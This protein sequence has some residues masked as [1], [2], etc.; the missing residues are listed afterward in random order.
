MFRGLTVGFWA[1]IFVAAALGVCFC[2]TALAR[3]TAQAEDPVSHVTQLNRDALAAIDKR[4]FEKARELLKRAL[5]VCDSAGLDKHA[6]AAR[7]HVHM[8]VVIIEGFKNRELGLKQFAKALEIEPGIA[9]TKSLSTPEIDEA[10]AEAKGHGAG[11]AVAA[12][13]G[14]ETPARP[15]AGDGE[16]RASAARPAGE[17]SPRPALSPNGL[18]YHTL[19][20]VKQGASIVVTVNVEDTLRFRK[21]VL[22]YR[23]QGTSEFLGR[24]MEAVG[25]GAYRAEIPDR[26]TTGATDAYYIEAQD[27]DGQPVAQR[28][29]EERPLV[30]SFATAARP[31]SGR[32]AA[33]VADRQAV[34]RK[35]EDEDEEEGTGKYFVSLLVGSGF[36]YVS[37]NGEVNADMHVPGTVSGALLAHIA[38]EFGYWITPTFMLSGQ[39][40]LQLVTGPTELDAG[41]HTYSPVPAAIAVFA[42]ATWLLGSGDL[43]PF[44]SGGLG[45]GQIRHVVT[46]GN[47]TDCGSSHMET[48]KDSVAAGP[49]LGEVG[50]GLIYK[51]GKTTGVVASSNVEAAVPNFTINM[52]FNLGVALNF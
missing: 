8:G 13:A 35:S 45:I 28:G 43:R 29:S 34:T 16:G 12:T 7:T 42:K 36:G 32:A 20:E 38:P 21:I 5:D 24:E 11:G 22:A 18:S 17:A 39:G 2:G 4:E 26:A 40:R 33:V 50:A 41:G 15:P 31:S 14:D 27:D 46:F 30:I 49:A 51:V 47:L 19:S 25:N 48:C 37:G 6:V 44:V 1:R 3:T 23:P 9:M 10:F 52:D